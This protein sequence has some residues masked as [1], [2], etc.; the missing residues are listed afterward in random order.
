[1]TDLAAWI[2]RSETLTDLITPAPVRGLNATLDREPI[3]V[4][5]GL[6]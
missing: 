2:G 5:A 1:M 6:V 4:A 3:E